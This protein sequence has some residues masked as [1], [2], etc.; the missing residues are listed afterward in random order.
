MLQDF[1]M[2]KSFSV[3]W[4]LFRV[5]AKSSSIL[6]SGQ[7]AANPFFTPAGHNPVSKKSIRHIPQCVAFSAIL[8]AVSK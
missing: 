6:P 7:Y 8:I 4:S 2:S 3:G 5:K 1:T